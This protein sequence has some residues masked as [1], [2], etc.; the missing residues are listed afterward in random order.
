MRGIVLFPIINCSGAMVEITSTEM[1]PP[2]KDSHEFIPM[3]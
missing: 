1:T 2:A 3:R